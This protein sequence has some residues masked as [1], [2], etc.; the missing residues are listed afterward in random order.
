ML[1]EERSISGVSNVSKL[2][3]SPNPSYTFVTQ[4]PNGDI[5]WTGHAWKGGGVS[6]ERYTENCR[7]VWNDPL[8]FKGSYSHFGLTSLNDASIWNI[9]YRITY[10]PGSSANY[11][12]RPLGG[13]GVNT[14]VAVQAGDQAVVERLDGIIYFYVIRANG[15]RIDF[16][17]VAESNADMPLRAGYYAGVGSTTNVLTMD[18]D[19]YGPN[20]YRFGFNGYENEPKVAGE[21]SVIDFGARIYDS[22]LG[23]FLS[24]DPW[25][26]KYGW[27]STYAY[28][29]NSPAIVV[30]FRGL[31]G[32]TEKKSNSQPTTLV[33]KIVPAGKV[34]MK[35][36]I[37]S[38]K[39]LLIQAES[40]ELANEKLNEYM[41]SNPDQKKFQKMILM[42]HASP[43]TVRREGEKVRTGKYSLRLFAY[44]TKNGKT[45]RGLNSDNMGSEDKGSEVA[46]LESIFSNLV[47]NGS[48]VILGCQLAD[49]Q[50]VIKD[51]FG[52]FPQSNVKLYTDGDVTTGGLKT[53]KY[54]R[55]IDGK[56]VSS[57]EEERAVVYTKDEAYDE[58]WT[59]T[60]RGP[61]GVP[62]N[63]SIG[64]LEVDT[65][66]QEVITIK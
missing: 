49:D 52:I 56:V 7:V 45:Y 1:I 15:I 55:R 2:T 8:S 44:K 20:G 11:T 61:D 4:L 14:G 65:S 29:K 40:I 25:D 51:I 27:Q 6:K 21:G 54:T 62:T 53:K 5:Q 28:F 42:A 66:T 39:T 3:H 60:T 46:A 26:Y 32:N 38:R 48:C 36:R 10:Y 16:G 47:E 41:K 12:Y 63:T 24:I 57:R 22:R 37:I 9:E 34:K 35:T 43:R 17:N 58:G 59:L 18:L 13:T 33:I 50:Q 23:R 64:Q 30:D 31:G 19:F